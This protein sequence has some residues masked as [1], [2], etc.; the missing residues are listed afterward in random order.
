MHKYPIAFEDIVI[1]ILTGHYHG[2][3]GI[4]LNYSLTQVQTSWN[5]NQSAYYSP[6][7]S[8]VMGF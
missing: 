6:F 1:P 2:N 7:F 8:V 3:V 5:T 4:E